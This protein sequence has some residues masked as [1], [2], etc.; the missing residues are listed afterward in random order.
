MARAPTIHSDP[1]WAHA[2]LYTVGCRCTL[3]LHGPMLCMQ[4]TGLTGAF[5]IDPS[6]VKGRTLLNLDTEV[7]S[8]HPMQPMRPMPPMPLMRSD[9]HVFLFFYGAAVIYALSADIMWGP[10]FYI[11]IERPSTCGVCVFACVGRL[12]TAALTRGYLKPFK[13]PQ[14]PI[15]C[16]KPWTSGRICPPPCAA[17]LPALPP[18]L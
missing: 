12:C 13:A 14:T 4:E 18:L 10:C 11:I 1:A 5:E 7:N 16:C 15:R 17:A 2:I 9:A 8:M 3:I 6:L